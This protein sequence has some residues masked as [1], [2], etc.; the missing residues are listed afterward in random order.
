LSWPFLH[1]AQVVG[2]GDAF[3][4]GLGGAEAQQL[5]DALLVGVVLADALLEHLAEMLP[6]LLEVVGPVLGDVVQQ[7]QGLAHAAVADH[8]HVP[9]LLQDF[10]GDVEGAGRRRR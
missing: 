5:G 10:P 9:G 2:Q 8:L 4:V 6:D 7:V 3:L 1:A